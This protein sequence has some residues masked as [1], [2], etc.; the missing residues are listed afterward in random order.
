MRRQNSL[1]VYFDT[2]SDPW[3]SK[4][5]FNLVVCEATR[6]TDGWLFSDFMWFCMAMKEHGVSGDFLS[7]FPV[8]DYLGSLK[9]QHKPGVERIEFA[10]I[11]Y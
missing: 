7:C 9:N 1:R 10:R 5:S 4:G 6:V 3:P 8:V 11:A 2:P